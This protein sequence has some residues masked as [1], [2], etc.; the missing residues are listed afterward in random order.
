MIAT[1]LVK[2]QH[3]SVLERNY[4]HESVLEL[5]E[6]VEKDPKEEDTEPED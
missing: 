1:L 5:V 4:H 2:Y 6:V 3:E